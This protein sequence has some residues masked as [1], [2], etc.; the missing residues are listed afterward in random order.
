M[1]VIASLRKTYNLLYSYCFVT[2]KLLWLPPSFGESWTECPSIHRFA[3]TILFTTVYLCR[4][5]FVFRRLCWFR[6]LLLALAFLFKKA[7]VPT[8]CI[9]RHQLQKKSRF[10]AGTFWFLRFLTEN[11][12]SPEVR[13][14]AL[15]SAAV[16]WEGDTFNYS[17]NISWG[18]I[19][20]SR[21]SLSSQ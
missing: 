20:W 8:S 19:P 5:S 7:I 2:S 4:I 11:S 13:R 3:S 12:C 14:Y 6:W 9:T 21:N 10:W 15:L 1:K 16:W 18:D 17:F